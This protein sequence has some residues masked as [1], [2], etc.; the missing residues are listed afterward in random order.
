M[1]FRRHDKPISYYLDR[2]QRR[3]ER[4]NLQVRCTVVKYCC[5]VVTKRIKVRSYILFTS[6]RSVIIEHVAIFQRQHFISW[7]IVGSLQWLGF[8]ACRCWVIA[9]SQWENNKRW[10]VIFCVKLQAWHQC[11]VEC[12]QWTS[13][14]SGTRIIFT[15][16]LVGLRFPLAIL[17]SAVNLVG[18]QVLGLLNF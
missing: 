7:E 5:S 11:P 9:L 17:K 4:L 13:N 15:E 10:W 6:I 3:K 16:D 14:H 2:H 8:E 12:G 1:L 18:K